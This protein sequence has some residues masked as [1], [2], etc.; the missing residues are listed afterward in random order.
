VYS[1]VGVLILGHDPVL[2]ETRRLVLNR[3]GIQVWTASK[4]SEAVDCLLNQPIDLFILCQTLSTEACEL[5]L[6]T[7][8][9]L[10]PGM[11]N[12][13]LGRQRFGPP[14]QDNDTFLSAFLSPRDLI[15]FIQNKMNA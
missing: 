14:A 13:L 15:A 4:A 6:E 1:S 11:M 9:T 12:L 7:A 8:H 2:L 3:A 5:M 10:R